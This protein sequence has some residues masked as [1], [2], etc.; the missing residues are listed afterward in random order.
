MFAVKFSPGP[1]SHPVLDPGH[2]PHPPTDG[3]G[4]TDHSRSKQEESRGFGRRGRGFGSDGERVVDWVALAAEFGQI[5]GAGG[6][7]CGKE[8]G[9]SGGVATRRDKDRTKEGEAEAVGDVGED[10]ALA[11]V[12]DAGEEGEVEGLVCYAVGCAGG[13]DGGNGDEVD[14]IGE[15]ELRGQGEDE[16]MR[17]AYECGVEC[18]GV[19]G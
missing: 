16:G 19:G 14:L 3:G 18:V 6:N 8:A 7:V 5:E 1:P 10:E 11:G 17:V 2:S 13:L 9:G 12:A 15:G 4:K